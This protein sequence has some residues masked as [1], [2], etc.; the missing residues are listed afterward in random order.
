MQVTVW[1]RGSGRTVYSGPL[2]ITWDGNAKTVGTPLPASALGQLT[3]VKFST[4][5]ED[6]FGGHDLA[7][8]TIVPLGGYIGGLFRPGDH[9]KITK[10]GATCFEGEYSS[11]VPADDGKIVLK[12]KGYAYNLTDYDSVFWRQKASDDDVYY[13]T[14]R[15]VGGNLSTTWYGWD[16]ATD[17]LGMPISQVVGTIPAGAYGSAESAMSPAPVKLGP[18]LTERLRESGERWAVW[19][20]TLVIAAD[21]TDP[22]W[23]Y[24]ASDSVVG[25]ADT[26][27]ATHVGVWFVADGEPLWSSAVTYTLNDLVEY[28]GQT[29]ASLQ[30]G[31]TNHLPDAD[32][33]TWWTAAAT[34]RKPNDFS[35][36]WAVDTVGLARFDARTAVVDYRGLGLITGVR[37]SD[38]AGNLLAL[39]K[40]RF[41]LSGSFMV[42]PSSGFTSINDGVADLAL[43]HAG[44]IL[45]LSELRTSQGNLMTDGSDVMIGQ[46]EYTWEAPAHPY[47][48]AVESLTVTPM[49]AIPR[50]LGEVLRGVPGADSSIS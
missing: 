21:P 34:V 47:D 35:M 15:L 43:V 45:R 17:V 29:W 44:T 11:A 10:S 1:P 36:A 6:G 46:T 33:S 3:N 49:G 16:Y 14:T 26:E 48:D 40:G 30:N 4:R 27:Y 20:R 22:V 41:I 28:G 32:G 24:R 39:V 5:Y 19:G 23:K 8:W 12:A 2:G 7:E 13:P 42:T 9:V 25:V 18:V 31:N 50:N 38:I 37:A